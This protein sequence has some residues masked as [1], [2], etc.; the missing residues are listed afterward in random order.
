MV[1][2][3]S[4]DGNDIPPFLGGNNMEQW[5]HSPT[6]WKLGRCCI[7][8]AGLPGS[9]YPIYPT[10][11]VW[12][13]K[14]HLRCILPSPPSNMQ[15]SW[16]VKPRTKITFKTAFIWEG[17]H[18]KARK[19]TRQGTHIFLFWKNISSPREVSAQ[20]RHFRILFGP[21]PPPRHLPPAEGT[22]CGVSIQESATC[23]AY[24]RAQALTKLFQQ[25]TSS[26]ARQQAVCQATINCFP[27]RCKYSL[28]TRGFSVYSNNPESQFWLTEQAFLDKRN[29]VVFR[30]PPA[31]FDH[32]K[33]RKALQSYTFTIPL[34]R[35]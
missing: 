3:S 13:R 15:L 12:C 35:K 31:V 20:S 19:S 10:G 32:T 22:S 2:F 26:A 24:E 33:V 14:N 7:D 30:F 25:I 9:G 4:R 1:K 29:P 28:W 21:M 5:Y 18:W 34:P 16:D 27:Q 17:W 11:Q 6:W 23:Q 8:F